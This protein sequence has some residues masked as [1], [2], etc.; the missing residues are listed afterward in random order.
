MSRKEKY[1]HRKKE[2]KRQRRHR[3]IKKFALPYFIALNNPESKKD[4]GFKA[5]HEMISKEPRLKA[6]IEKHY[7]KIKQKS[8]KIESFVWPK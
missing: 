8:V 1:I 5:F 7:E 4:P 2:N 6:L 3:Q